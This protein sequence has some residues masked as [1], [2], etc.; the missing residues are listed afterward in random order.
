MYPFAG[1][2]DSIHWPSENYFIGQVTEEEERPLRHVYVSIAA[3]KQETSQ[4]D[5]N[6]SSLLLLELP[7]VGGR[8]GVEIYNLA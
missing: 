2:Q 3:P 4:Q 5:L 8:G 6:C 1:I 7:R